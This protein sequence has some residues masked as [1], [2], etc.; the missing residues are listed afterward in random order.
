MTRIKGGIVLVFL[1]LNCISAFSQENEGQLHGNFQIDG[2][3]YQQDTLIGASV[4]EQIFGLNSYANFNY[5]KG[6]F[7]AG[8]RYEGYFPPL[9]GYDQ[10]YEG[11]GFPYKYASYNNDNIE[12][13][14]GSFYEQF[15]SGLTLRTYEEKNLG[16]DNAMEGARIRYQPFPGVYIKALIG[17]QRNFWDN[18]GLVRGADA[19]FN[20]NELV[21][22]LNTAKMQISLGGSVVSKYQVDKDPIYVLPKNVAAGAGRFNITSGKISINGEYAYK[23][24]DPSSDNGLIYKSGNALLFNATY[25]QKGLGIFLGAKRIDNMSFRSDRGKKLSEL[26]INYI[27]D[28]TKN[29]AYSLTAMYPYATQLNGE[30]GLQS[31]IMYKFKKGSLLAGQHG[32]NLVVNYSVAKNINKSAPSDTNIIGADGTLGYSSEFFKLGDELFYSDFNIDFNKKFS[33]KFKT[34]IIYQYLSYNQDF[35]HGANNDLFH[36]MLYAHIV[37]TD[38]TYRY[39]SKK[40]QN[41]ALRLELQNLT[42]EDDYGDW[43]MALLEFSVP[44]WFFTVMDQYNYGN[45]DSN[46]KIHYYSAA[47]GYTNK[48]TRIELGYG[49]RKAGVL[50]V[51]GICRPVPASNGFSITIA[52]SF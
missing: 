50:C 44:N 1:I 27:P 48:S 43:G 24:N 10:R 32:A 37:V 22:K 7:T 14:I 29:H 42:T 47:I 17:R 11:V 16:Y 35:I 26:S 23:A 28:V 18:S 25:S 41:H 39:K 34:S 52:S 36:G 8:V 33:K 51:G 9:Q 12:I 46:L 20:L 15:G 5:T 6:A 38:M 30:M 40:S 21:K 49:K 3:Y 45:D 19:E 2:Q 13:T 31:E 4:P